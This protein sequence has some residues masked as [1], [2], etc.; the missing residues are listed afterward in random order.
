MSDFEDEG[1]ESEPVSQK[2]RLISKNKVEIDLFD[3]EDKF[4][5]ENNCKAVL[6]AIKSRLDRNFNPRMVREIDLDRELYDIIEIKS[7]VENISMMV[8]RG[9]EVK[10]IYA[11]ENVLTAE[12]KSKIAHL[13]ATYYNILG[14]DTL[15]SAKVG[16]DRKTCD[17]LSTL[18]IAR[19]KEAEDDK[20][21]EYERTVAQDQVQLRRKATK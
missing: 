18:F 3:P 21:K 6:S 16:L 13:C 14:S 10:S 4:S 19:A 20:V 12:L 1:N 7:F 2:G 5:I 11:D 8:F 9:D 15:Q 17:E